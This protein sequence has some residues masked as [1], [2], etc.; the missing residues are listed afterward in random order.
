MLGILVSWCLQHWHISS[1]RGITSTDWPESMLLT[2]S[3]PSSGPILVWLSLFPWLITHLPL[4]LGCKQS[5]SC[6]NPIIGAFKLCPDINITV[7]GGF[8]SVVLY[9][10]GH[11]TLSLVP[12]FPMGI[13]QWVYKGMVCLVAYKHSIH[14]IWM[15]WHSLEYFLN[16]FLSIP[17]EF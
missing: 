13:K 4:L 12:V 2:H 15:I 3:K 1:S 16:L 10:P 7:I 5:F 8:L 9:A 14:W 11:I 6:L 17:L